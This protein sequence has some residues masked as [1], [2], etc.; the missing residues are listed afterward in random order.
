MILSRSSVDGKGDFCLAP[1]ALTAVQ[2]AAKEWGGNRKFKQGPRL[3]EW[4]WCWWY[5]LCILWGVHFELQCACVYWEWGKMLDPILLFHS[6][7]LWRKL[8]GEVMHP[9]SASPNKTHFPERDQ[10]LCLFPIRT[11]LVVTEMSNWKCHQ[12]RGKHHSM[13]ITDHSLC[14][15]HYGNSSAERK[16]QMFCSFQ[17]EEI[18]S[19]HYSV[20]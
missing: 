16:G 14:T 3:K 9:I 20:L 2:L 8:A 18:T 10:M 19:C 4:L 7:H 17:E 11:M 5:V 13:S 1:Q 12:R 15:R 6:V